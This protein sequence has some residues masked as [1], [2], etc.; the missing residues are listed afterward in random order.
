MAVNIVVNSNVDST[1]A[2][3]RKFEKETRGQD[4]KPVWAGLLNATDGYDDQLA[5]M[6][7]VL[8]GRLKKGSR[9]ALFYSQRD[10]QAVAGVGWLTAPAGKKATRSRQ[11][12]MASVVVEV[13]HGILKRLS[14]SAYAGAKEKFA[15]GFGD[16]V[17]K[18]LKRIA[19]STPNKTTTFGYSGPTRPRKPNKIRIIRG[20]RY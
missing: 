18:E 13:E 17:E 3:F 2:L 11:R 20:G 19:A 8:T 1:L 9:R 4:S 15:K 12:F 10:Q 14:A 6:T 16:S 7:P 5:G